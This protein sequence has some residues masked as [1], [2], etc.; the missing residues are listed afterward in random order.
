[1]TEG[2]VL[3][4]AEAERINRVL[5]LVDRITP[6]MRAGLSALADFYNIDAEDPALLAIADLLAALAGEGA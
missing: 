6:E 2:H 5:T 1:M 4:A 3:T